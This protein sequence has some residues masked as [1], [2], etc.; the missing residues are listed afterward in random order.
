MQRCIEASQ[1][2]RAVLRRGSA[3]GAGCVAVVLLCMTGTQ[4]AH[5]QVLIA[6]LLGDKVSNERFQLGLNVSFVGTGLW[7]V[8]DDLLPSWSLSL[9][10][11]IAITEHFRLQP[12][13]GMK[14]PAGG[15]HMRPPIPG[16]EIEP[17][18][19][20]VYDDV[21]LRGRLAREM[22]YIALP[23]FAK[24]VLNPVALGLAPQLSILHH[25][26]DRVQ[27][28]VNGTKVAIEDGSL[29]GRLQRVD[30]GFVGSLEYAFAP[31]HGMR[32]FRVRLQGYLGLVDTV[33]DNPDKAVRNWNF[34][35]G[36]D[37]P[38]GGH[39]RVTPS[40]ASS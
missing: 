27:E 12:Q 22:R 2:K 28:K 8:S 10:G 15:R 14:H 16:Y 11:E 13:L 34:S 31:Q 20:A 35:L 1:P 40:P 6:L 23:V 36:V 4:R 17:I 37:I 39:K 5:A 18:G 26:K 32:T 30:F 38:I 21:A 19:D 9:Y 33:K 25:A 7:G 24:W 3:L 29:E